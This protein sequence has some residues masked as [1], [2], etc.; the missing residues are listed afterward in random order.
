MN[1]IFMTVSTAQSTGSMEELT[2]GNGI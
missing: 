2:L 1:S